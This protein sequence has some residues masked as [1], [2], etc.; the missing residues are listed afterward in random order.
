[1]DILDASDF[2]G[3]NLYDTG[4]YSTAPGIV[5]GGVAAVPEPGT[6][7]IAVVVAIALACRRTR[8]AATV[9]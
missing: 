5:S 4:N 1:V 8:Q 2:F 3:T 6:A 9:A 7:A